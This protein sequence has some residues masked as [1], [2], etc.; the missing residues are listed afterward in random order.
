MY[1]ICLICIQKLNGLWAGAIF[2]GTQFDA[3]SDLDLSTKLSLFLAIPNSEAS[4]NSPPTKEKT[5]GHVR[6]VTALGRQ[7]EAVTQTYNLTQNCQL[8]HGESP[9]FKPRTL[10]IYS[11]HCIHCTSDADSVADVTFRALPS[12]DDTCASSH[13]PSPIQ[14]VVYIR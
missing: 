14:P 5:W 7:F 12:A 10:L 8:L 4:F 6:T 13:P 11:N 2:N 1:V 9:G 3:C